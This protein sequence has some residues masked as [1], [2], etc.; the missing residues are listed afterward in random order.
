MIDYKKTMDRLLSLP[1][2]TLI[3]T[4][5]TGTDFLQSLFDSHPEVLTF[6]GKS[7][8]HKFWETESKC[9]A[10]SHFDLID[11]LDEYIGYHFELF[12][13]RYDL[14][15]RKDQLGDNYDQIIDIDL[16]QFKNQASRL[17]EGRELNSKNVMLAVYAAYALCLG[18]DLE[19][20]KLF[21][22]HVHQF[23][24][25][26]GFLKDFP[27]SKIICMTRDPRANIVSG[28]EHWKK[29]DPDTN[30]ETFF[31]IYIK[32]ILLDAAIL[33]GL[34]NEYV[35]V[36]IEDLGDAQILIKLCQWLNINYHECLTKSTW[37]G[38]GWHGDRLSAKLNEAAGWSQKILQNKWEVKL[39]RIDK[40]VLNYIMY[41]RLR[42]Y[43]YACR[44]L[45]VIDAL[46][47]PFCIVLPLSFERKY[48]SFQ[49]LK[50]CIKRKRYFLI[51]ENI[52]YYLLRIRLFMQYYWRVTAREKYCVNILLA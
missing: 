14:L 32:R 13:S 12:K 22:H 9:A 10:A 33:N 28:I 21:F 24:L 26:P 30:K 46:L 48:F 23:E 34:P 4:G 47:A 2:C 8:F 25:M 38:L 17:L 15:E 7:L 31:Y 39:G 37:N 43:G 42:R 44:R 6:N 36:R 52:I 51:V 35:T 20:K 40:F 49:Y 1:A 5:R 27:G 50:D 11:L 18:Q 19:K 3:T 45:T 16:E 29:Y 41:Y